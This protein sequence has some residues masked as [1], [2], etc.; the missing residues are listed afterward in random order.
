MELCAESFLPPYKSEPR[1]GPTHTAPRPDAC[2]DAAERSR[3][4]CLPH[5]DQNSQLLPHTSHSTA[6]HSWARTQ[7][8]EVAQPKDK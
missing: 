6:G 8:T 1:T 5:H 7:H 3:A 2:K 4:Q